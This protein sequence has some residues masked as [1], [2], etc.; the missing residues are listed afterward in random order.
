MR[1]G[2]AAPRRPLC[3]GAALA[4]AGGASRSLPRAALL[5]RPKHHGADGQR[6]GKQAAQRRGVP[7]RPARPRPPHR[8]HLPL[9]AAVDVL[10]HRRV[11][12]PH[13]RDD[14][15]H[16]AQGARRLHRGGAGARDRDAAHRFRRPRG[17]A[18]LVARAAPPLRR[19]APGRVWRLSPPRQ[20]RGRRQPL[21]RA[22]Q[23]AVAREGDARPSR[24]R[25]RAR[26][27]CAGQMGRLSLHGGSGRLPARAPRSPVQ[28]VDGSRLPLGDRR[29]DA[30]ARQARAPDVFAPRAAAARH[31]YWGQPLRVLW[32][33]RFETT[34][35]TISSVQC[36]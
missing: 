12:Q 11:A 28:P 33:V 7:P 29:A 2:P 25:R 31:C 15:L 5:P 23:K 10:R 16:D 18:R 3:A 6:A 30:R 35:S 32:L 9:R 21:R 36:G 26:D 4:A 34:I 27:G 24:R 22:L 13:P 1:F 8:R 20:A 14:S 19:A 17:R